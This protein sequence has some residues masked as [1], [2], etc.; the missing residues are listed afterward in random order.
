[1]RTSGDRPAMNGGTH[2]PPD[3]VDWLSFGRRAVI[4]WPTTPIWSFLDV[5]AVLFQYRAQRRDGSR[6]VTF[7]RVSAEAHGAGDLCFRQI[8]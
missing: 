5:L 6:R 2:A 3:P 1:M 8:P 4:E 7:H